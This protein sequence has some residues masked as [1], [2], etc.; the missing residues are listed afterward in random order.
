MLPDAPSEAEYN[1]M[2]SKVLRDYF[3]SVPHFSACCG[4]E[5]MNILKSVQLASKQYKIN[6]IEYPNFEN[7][8][9]IGYVSK[10]NL[11]HLE[12]DTMLSGSDYYNVYVK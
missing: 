12:P 11:V 10:S 1:A 9:S 3:I 6:P 2:W 8:G 7:I 4:T 5:Y